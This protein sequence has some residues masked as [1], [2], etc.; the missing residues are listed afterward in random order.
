MQIKDLPSSNTLA[1]TDVLAKD[2][3]G[4]ATQRITGQHLADGVKS[5]AGAASSNQLADAYSSSATY[6][7]GNLCI[8]DN[9][10]YKCTTAIETAEAWNAAH[11]TAT[12]LDEVM[13]KYADVVNNLVSTTAG[14]VLDARQGKVLSDKM[15]W[16]NIGYQDGAGS[17]QINYDYTLYNELLLI[18]QQ[19]NSDVVSSIVIVAN[20][21]STPVRA[22]Y[23]TD[24]NSLRY[25]QFVRY[26]GV[27]S[28]SNDGYEAILY[29][30]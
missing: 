30:R 25:G 10:L 12:T 17:K 13:V 4:G 18:L 16:T 7:V 20:T 24:D 19:T 1:A 15:V 9:T 11:W 21:S 29:A 6:A 26:T 2:T 14:K 5:L 22:I 28:V 23:R 3:S 27:L 8:Y